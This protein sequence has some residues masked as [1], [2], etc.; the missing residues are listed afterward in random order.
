MVESG[1]RSKII[2]WVR[3]SLLGLFYYSLITLS[4]VMAL[5]RTIT[6]ELNEDLGVLAA[7]LLAIWA[8]II[9]STLREI[10]YARKLF[11]SISTNK[12]F[13]F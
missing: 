9:Y 3:P 4:T 6:G 1:G 11:D 5:W 2:L 12:P 7:I 10:R 8:Y 13:P